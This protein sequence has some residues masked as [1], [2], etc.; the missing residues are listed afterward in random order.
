MTDK[1]NEFGNPTVPH[2]Y[3]NITVSAKKAM[4]IINQFAKLK[5]PLL[6]LGAPG[7][8]KTE[9]FY[10]TM[11][12]PAHKFE[13][14]VI[15]NPQNLDAVDM[16]LPYLEDV[17]ME[18]K[19]KGQDGKEKVEYVDSKQCSFAI[20]D[21]FPRQ[22]ATAVILDD[23]AHA[24]PT[25]EPSFYSLLREKRVGTYY[26][27][28]NSW[29]SA[30]GN[31]VFHKTGAKQLTTAGRNRVT[32]I[33][34]V[35]DSASFFD[36]GL[37]RNF[38]ASI[39]GFVKHFPGAVNGFCPDEQSAGC[40]PRSLETLSKLMDDGIPKEVMKEVV[41]GTIGA[42]AGSKFYAYFLNDHL[43]NI[44][45]NEI[46]A[47]PSTCEL[48]KEKDVLWTVLI[49]IQNMANKKT[50]NSIVEILSRKEVGKSLA[51]L[52]LSNLVQNKSELILNSNK[53]I[54]NNKLVSQM[55]VEYAAI[56]V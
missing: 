43:K 17:K 36:I 3:R 2:I 56:V 27:P 49:A 8:G 37:K 21:L 39:M 6:V 22:G 13:N 20:S 34:V 4:T 44:N 26:L 30:T 41:F 19:I 45:L 50:I 52:I 24:G 55:L 47:N 5:L 38:N 16:K 15:L 33:Y 7:S 1:A 10:Q 12:N 18:I 23:F 35:P 48:P 11:E 32:S 28:P 25:L 46:L 31:C 53:K 54:L 9:I 42:N 40:T 29:V 14:H 51:V